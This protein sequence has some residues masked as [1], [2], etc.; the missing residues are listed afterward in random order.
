MANVPANREHFGVALGKAVAGKRLSEGMTQAGL[1][2]RAGEIGLRWSEDTVQ[3]LEAGR[4]DDVGT[5]ELIKLAEIFQVMPWSFFLGEGEVDLGDG[6]YISRS[7]LRVRLGG[8]PERIL[9]K[10]TRGDQADPL[11]TS[12]RAYLAEA[13]SA[14]LGVVPDDD[15]FRIE[16]N[17]RAFGAGK[18][19]ADLFATRPTDVER[20]IAKQ[21]RVS[22]KTIIE[23]SLELWDD[24]IDAARDKRA[25]ALKDVTPRQ[26]QARRGHETRKLIDEL[27]ARVAERRRARMQTT[28][29]TKEKRR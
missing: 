24:R 3:L 27:R 15:A 26:R 8:P 16:R 28:R 19:W 18:V 6:V 2:R 29:H 25:G 14:G 5:K 22:T 21:L 20:D 10:H 11:T 1:A 13:S 4:R 23:L 7:G 9:R 12:E 17:A